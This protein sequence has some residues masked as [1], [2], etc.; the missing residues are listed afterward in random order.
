MLQINGLE[1]GLEV[2][3]CLGSEVR[4]EIVKLLAENHEMNL[5]ELA[6]GLGLTNGALTA[7][8]RKLEECGIIQ[9]TTAHTGRGLQK[10]CSLKVDQLLLNVYPAEEEGSMKMYETSIRIGHYNDYS[11]HP[12]CG[13]A[14]ETALVGA[15]NDPRC[16]SWPQRLEAQMLWLHDGFVEYRIPNL[17]PEK[18]EIVQLT[19]SFEISGADQ[20]SEHDTQSELHFRLNGEEIGR[21]TTLPARDNA[22]GIYTPPGW[23]RKERR[24][25]YLK[26]LVV[27][28]TGSYL[29][30]VKVADRD[31]A[32]PFLDENNEMKIRFEAHPENGREGGLALYGSGFG[33]YKQDIL[34]RVHYM[35]EGT[36]H[37]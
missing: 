32:A 36:V 19:I 31:P 8:I 28:A 16:F 27:N 10:I 2:F 37:G 12:G 24:Y 23:N 17:L 6:S 1:Q 26:M 11:V 9:I 22:R 20:G 35:P 5:N 21:W 18:Q 15:E 14:G 4:M 3:K 13:L 25:G 33:N 7:H 29:D 30:G 34:V